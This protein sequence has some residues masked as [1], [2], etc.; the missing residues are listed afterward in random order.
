VGAD[1]NRIVNTGGVLAFVKDI[2]EEAWLQQT[3]WSDQ[4]GKSLVEWGDF[5]GQE[6]H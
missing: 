3:I 4:V 2:C 1:R 6:Y 5:D